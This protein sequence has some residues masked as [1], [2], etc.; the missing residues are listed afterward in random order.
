MRVKGLRPLRVQGRAL[1]PGPEALWVKEFRDYAEPL[2]SQA[3]SVLGTEV[4]LWSKGAR[5]RWRNDALSKN[6][7]AM[8]YERWLYRNRHD[9]L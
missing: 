4:L 5:P 8:T 1:L 9:Q 7:H 2:G 3:L 6:V